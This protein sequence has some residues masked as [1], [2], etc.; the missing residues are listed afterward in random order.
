MRYKSQVASRALSICLTSIMI[1]ALVWLLMTAINIRQMDNYH[2]LQP[3]NCVST[4]VMHPS[5]HGLPYR[6]IETRRYLVHAEYDHSRKT[7]N[8]ELLLN[9]FLQR[10]AMKGYVEW[11]KG[12]SY[13]SL[14]DCATSTTMS[15][16]ESR[17]RDVVLIECTT[18]VQEG[19]I[20]EIRVFLTN[21]KDGAK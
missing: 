10:R 13:V 6:S 16:A 1:I 18:P 17:Q 20:T 15:C 9:G 21:Q 7:V 8:A 12:D 4:R 14:I 5:S 2:F 19:L 11:V 3:L